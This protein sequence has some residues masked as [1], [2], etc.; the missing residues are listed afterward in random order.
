MPQAGY[1]LALY[2][3]VSRPA[4]GVGDPG[5]NEDDSSAVSARRP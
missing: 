4:A 3:P 5:Y 2:T 1:E